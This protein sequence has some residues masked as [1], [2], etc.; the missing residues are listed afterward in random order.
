VPGVRLVMVELQRR[1]GK[2]KDSVIEGRD[3]GTVVFPDAEK[4]FFLD[5]AHHERVQRRLKELVEK[6][7]NVTSADIAKDIQNR[8]R[9][10]STRQCAPLKRADDAIYIDTT[11][12]SI[13]EVVESLYRKVKEV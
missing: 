10:D 12:M 2:N 9:I 8:D 3:I 6:G 11:N 13:D 7:Q 1:L 4:K 5:A